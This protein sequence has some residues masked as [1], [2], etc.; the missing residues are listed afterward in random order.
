MASYINIGNKAFA[1]SVNDEYVDK[2]G[3]IAEV[4][5]TLFKR[6]RFSCVSRCR[7]F[8]KSMAAEM[9][10]AYYDR[11]CDSRKLFRGLQIEHHPDFEK[12][13]NKYPVIYV[14]M[15]NFMTRYRN[16][17]SVVSII[18]RSLIEDIAQC[19]ADVPTKEDDDL[20]AYLLRVALATGNQFIMII[21]EWDAICRE[22]GAKEKAMD[23]YVNLLRRMFKSIDAMRVFAGVYLTGIFPIKKYQTESAL[24]NFWEYSMIQ[25][26]GLAPFFGFTK[27][28][29][30]TLCEKYDMDFEE[31]AKWY[32]G[33]SIGDEPSMFNPSSVM[34]ALSFNKCSN[35]WATTGAFDA[36][37]RYIQMDFKGLR[38][39]IVSMLAGGSCP[40]NTTSFA[41]DPS[42]IHDRDEV[43]T[44]LIHLGYLAYDADKEVCYIPNMEVAEEMK[45]AVKRNGWQNVMDAINASEEL[46]ENLLEGEAE[47]VAAGVEK[48]HEESASILKYNNENALSCVINLAF[49]AARNKYKVIR[50]MPTGKGFA[51]VV[52]VPWRNVNL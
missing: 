3:L 30:Q 18:Q 50:E 17:N 43:L 41:N 27:S 1:S 22:F 34:K 39:D 8:G 44:V 37:A 5:D 9:L 14:D 24:N 21:D 6:S 26:A 11:S 35:F 46:L 52:F 40:V 36:V 28:E 20:M 49:Y 23:D 10:C 33:Y 31:M 2:T 25:P 15:T 48:V 47:A 29:V 19:Y 51:D 32:D 4:N 38:G 13:L 16:D 42:I 45:N 7:R 12:H